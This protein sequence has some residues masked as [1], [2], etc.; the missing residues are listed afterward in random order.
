MPEGSQVYTCLFQPPARLPLAEVT[1]SL[2]LEAWE[3]LGIDYLGLDF[4][5]ILTPQTAQLRGGCG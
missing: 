2:G 3:P 1:L 4:Q 5:E